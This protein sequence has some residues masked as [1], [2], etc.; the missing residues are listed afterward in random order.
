[1]R[2]M[3]AVTA[4]ASLLLIAAGSGWAGGKVSKSKT[5]GGESVADAGKDKETP[6]SFNKTFQWED[7]VVGPKTK[8]VDHDKIAAMQEQG[9]REDAAKRREPPK[10]AERAAPAVAK[11]PTMDIEKPMAARS[12]VRKAAY[13]Q[14]K[15]HDALDNLLAENGVGANDDASGHDGLGKVLGTSGKRHG[16]PHKRARHH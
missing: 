14:P 8:G 3:L 4:G 9:R 12:P 10:K 6:A 5:K 7:K 2:P 11:L 16:K 1:M 13:T 15:Q